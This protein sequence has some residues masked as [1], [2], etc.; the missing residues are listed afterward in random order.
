MR[1]AGWG[2]NI[3]EI[4]RLVL[5]SRSNHSPSPYPPPP[6]DAGAQYQSG[7]RPLAIER[8]LRGT[9]MLA[10]TTRWWVCVNVHHRS[11]F[12]THERPEFDVKLPSQIAIANG[13]NGQVSR[14]CLQGRS[15]PGAGVPCPRVLILGVRSLTA[16]WAR[17]TL[18]DTAW[19]ISLGV[20]MGIP[21]R[22]QWIGFCKGAERTVRPQHFSALRGAYRECVF[23]RGSVVTQ[24][25]SRLVPLG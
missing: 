12:A 20:D 10:P 5:W 19:A 3:S 9:L 23:C 24:A 14:H 4:M 6:Q 15:P 25:H 11:V 18:T 1:S 16:R 7:S 2:A 21:V 8:S 13:T 17:T 22:T